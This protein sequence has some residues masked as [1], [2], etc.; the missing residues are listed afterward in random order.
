MASHNKTEPQGLCSWEAS[1]AQVLLV[2]D[3]DDAVIMFQRALRRTGL[4]VD[5]TVAQDGDAALRA[6]EA[7]DRRFDLV[8]LD[9]HLPVRSGLDVLASLAEKKEQGPPVVVLTGGSSPD[10]AQEAY[11]LGAK[12]VVEA[13][14]DLHQL[15]EKLQGVC[16]TYLKTG[17]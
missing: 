2:Q 12:S 14:C 5:V 11:R 16:R 17:S 6:L 7:P 13:P 10:E 8:L 3:D 1:V 15:E 9:L 4:P